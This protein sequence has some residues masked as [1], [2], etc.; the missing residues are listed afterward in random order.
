MITREQFYRSK[1]W[2]AVRKVVIARDTDPETGFVPCAMCGKPIV[3]KYDLIVDHIDELDDLNVNNA[4]V[5]LNPDNL[6]CL[7]FKCH[8]E[9]HNRFTDGAKRDRLRPRKVYVVYGSPCSGKTT[10]VHEVSTEDDLIV[11]MDSIWES[12]SNAKRYQKPER[13]KGAAFE[14]RDKLYDIVKYRSGRWQD[15]YVITG[16][17]L[18]GDRERLKQRVGADE[19]VFIDTPEDECLLR[20]KERPREWAGYVKDWFERFQPEENPE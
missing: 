1:Q 5:A 7:H 15:A 18:Q 8:N 13:L 11:D 3:K 20:A 12:I 14:I 16:G 19:L 4:E 2:E 9:R 6:R 10:W 17:A